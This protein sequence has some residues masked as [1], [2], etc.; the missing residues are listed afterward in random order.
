MRILLYPYQPVVSSGSVSMPIGSSMPSSGYLCMVASVLETI[1][2]RSE[3]P[4][5]EAAS[6]T[7][8]V[9]LM[10]VSKYCSGVNGPPA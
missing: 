7:L 9:P 3:S 1:T 6:S 4:R 5:P 10:L 8:K 2:C